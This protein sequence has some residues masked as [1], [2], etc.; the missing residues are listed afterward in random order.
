[1]RVPHQTWGEIGIAFIVTDC[2]LL[3]SDYLGTFLSGRLAKFKAPREVLTLQR[4]PY[5]KV[6]ELRKSKSLSRAAESG[7]E[8]V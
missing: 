1:M 5:G 7:R 8:G 2:L 3:T 4:T 6:L